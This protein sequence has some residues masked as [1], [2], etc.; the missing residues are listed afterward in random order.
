MIESKW[1]QRWPDLF[2]GLPERQ[3]RGIVD[4][5]NNNVLEGWQPERADVELLTRS[6]RGELSEDDVIAQ[7]VAMTRRSADTPA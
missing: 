1:T 6:A 4:A 7:A 3:V 5:I 2:A